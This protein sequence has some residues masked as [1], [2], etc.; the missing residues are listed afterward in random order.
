MIIADGFL[1]LI[2]YLLNF[3]SFHQDKIFTRYTQVQRQAEKNARNIREQVKKAMETEIEQ[4]RALISDA[5]I[6]RRASND[7]LSPIESIDDTP[8]V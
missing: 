5:I 8:Q 6:Y 1:F 7:I 2:F 4:I 3:L